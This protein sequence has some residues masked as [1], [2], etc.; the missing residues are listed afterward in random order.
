[1]DWGM[2]IKATARAAKRSSRKK[3]GQY[4]FMSPINGVNEMDLGL[5]IRMTSYCPKYTSL[6]EKNTTF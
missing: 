4:P 5:G 3:E 6:L 2:V 1:M